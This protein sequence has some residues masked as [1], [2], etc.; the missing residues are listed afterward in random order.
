LSWLTAT[1]E[2]WVKF[3]PHLQRVVGRQRLTK[4]D[5]VYFETFVFQQED[6]GSEMN[7][8]G[9]DLLRW[10]IK[11]A[12]YG[13]PHQK[14][15]WWD[16]FKRANFGEKAQMDMWQ[17]AKDLIES[18]AEL[19][20]MLSA[21]RVSEFRPRLEEFIKDGRD[22]REDL[23]RDAL[24]S[25]AKRWELLNADMFVSMV[26]EFGHR[27]FFKRVHD[28]LINA[29]SDES[30]KAFL[31]WNYLNRLFQFDIKVDI[32][33]KDPITK[34]Y[35]TLACR[36]D[37]EALNR[38]LTWLDDLDLND[39]VRQCKEAWI[40]YG[41]LTLYDR[42]GEDE[43]VVVDWL[44]KAIEILLIA[45]DDF[46][47]VDSAVRWLTKRDRTRASWVSCLLAFQLPV[48]QRLERRLEVFPP[49]LGKLGEFIEQMVVFIP[50]SDPD[51]ET[52]WVSEVAKQLCN[53]FAF[54]PVRHGRPLIMRVFQAM[55]DRHD[56]EMTYKELHTKAEIET[57]M[58]WYVESLQPVA[59]DAR[60]C[61]EDSCG[62]MHGV[63][64]AILWTGGKVIHKRCFGPGKKMGE[65]SLETQ[66]ESPSRVGRPIKFR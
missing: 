45:R 36:Y 62:L 44:H 20:E 30:V 11:T 23:M 51:D 6:M 46:R 18:T 1:S 59:F 58:K 14:K 4:S 22:N 27:D 3:S 57:Q 63:G 50:Q 39:I 31:E 56:I 42:T 8:A 47:V 10:D 21:S 49:L 24:A 19:A 43:S 65:E 29:R 66:P 37:H 33:G 5:L 2:I 38:V 34:K 9:W 53:A 28:E 55:H 12:Q 35:L 16:R 13:Q 26:V 54:L 15:N 61:P 17:V 48:Y 40:V 7:K 25:N 32:K 52:T 41:L 60:I 64:E